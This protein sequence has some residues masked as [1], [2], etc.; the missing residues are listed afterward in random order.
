MGERYG[1]TMG[2]PQ[3]SEKFK[4]QDDKPGEQKAQEN[5]RGKFLRRK[6]ARGR[7]HWFGNAFKI[8]ALKDKVKTVH[9]GKRQLETPGKPKMEEN[10]II[11]YNS[12][13]QWIIHNAHYISMVH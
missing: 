7:F 9:A 3:D 5:I 10:T 1:R 8:L 2:T 13:L 4:F 6:N 11:A 12:I